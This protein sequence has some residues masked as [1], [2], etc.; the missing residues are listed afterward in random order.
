MLALVFSA[1]PFKVN[2]LLCVR[3][4][5][6]TVISGFTGNAREIARWAAVLAAFPVADGPGAFVVVA[7]GYRLNEGV[8]DFLD[9]FSLIVEFGM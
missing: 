1:P 2:R 8:F 9:V 7:H 5:L 6:C 4:S 3:C